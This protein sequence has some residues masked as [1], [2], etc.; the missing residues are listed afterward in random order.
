MRLEGLGQLKK[1]HLIGIRTRDL[2]ACNIV[3]QPTT[4]P[5]APHT[6]N[7]YSQMYKLARGLENKI[8]QEEKEIA[9]EFPG[10]WIL[11][12]V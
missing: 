6:S 7:S 9:E 2:P 8:T 4:L 1:I 10:W 5:R 11:K 12:F 3:P